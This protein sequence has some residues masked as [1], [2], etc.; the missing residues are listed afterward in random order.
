MKNKKRKKKPIKLL[1][2][3]QL[4]V[5]NPLMRKGGVHQ[6]SKSAKRFTDKIDIKK[7]LLS[8]FFLIQ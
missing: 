6:K 3:R 5:L 1:A 2:D 8:S 7:E 4:T